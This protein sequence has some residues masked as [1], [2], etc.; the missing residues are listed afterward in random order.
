MHRTQLFLPESLHAK[1]KSQ[2]TEDHKTLSE[3]VRIVLDEHLSSHTRKYTEKGIVSL[4]AM[5][6]PPEGE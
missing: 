5:T 4:M 3:Y 2:A 1:L 6:Q